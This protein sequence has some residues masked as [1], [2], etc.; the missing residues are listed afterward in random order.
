MSVIRTAFASPADGSRME[1]SL[2]FLPT[3]RSGHELLKLDEIKLGSV[4]RG[5]TKSVLD[6]DHSVLPA[7]LLESSQVR[8]AEQAV[9]SACHC[10]RR[11]ME[12]ASD[13]FDESPPWMATGREPKVHGL[14]RRLSACLAS[15]SVSMRD[16][17]ASL[18]LEAYAVELEEHQ[19]NIIEF[20]EIWTSFVD[21][22]SGEYS[23]HFRTRVRP[24]FV[25]AFSGAHGS[26]GHLAEAAKQLRHKRILF[27]TD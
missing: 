17:S 19:M 20:P 27:I 8:T 18:D 15:S 6:G 25:I 7:G 14:W 12:S 13:A 11:V 5:L 9:R 26:V 23:S 2:S 10:L 1:G 3:I 21:E 24:S 22:L 16:R 4:V